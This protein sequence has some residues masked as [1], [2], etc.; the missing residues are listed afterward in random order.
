MAERTYLARG[1]FFTRHPVMWVEDGK[2][3]ARST[4]LDGALKFFCASTRIEVDADKGTLMIWKRTWWL[5]HS[6]HEVPLGRMVGIEYAFK[7]GKI[8]TMHDFEDMSVS[9]TYRVTVVFRTTDEFYGPRETVDLF[10]FKGAGRVEHFNDQIIP[11]VVNVVLKESHS[12]EH[13]QKSLGFVELLQ[14]YTRANLI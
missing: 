7:Q 4:L 14:A 10:E 1:D 2:L 9:E 11:D 6:V 13:R 12:D 3:G 8:G 5:S